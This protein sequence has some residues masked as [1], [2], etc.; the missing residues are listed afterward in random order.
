M[1]SNFSKKLEIS[2]TLRAIVDMFDEDNRRPADTFSSS[3]NSVEPDFE[4]YDDN[5]YNEGGHDEP[6]TWDYVNDNQASVH[7]EGVYEG[8][9]ELFAPV[10]HEV[11]Y[12][13][14]HY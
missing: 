8:D 4:A 1:V 5:A 14:T 13:S 10:H 3:Q 7:D 9:E 6:S 12:H 2:P 11:H